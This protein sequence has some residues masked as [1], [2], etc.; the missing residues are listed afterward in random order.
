MSH[1][2]KCIMQNY[3]TPGAKHRGKSRWQWLFR[4]STKC[5]IHER[6]NY[7]LGFIKFKTSAC[8]RR[9]QG[10]KTSHRLGENTVVPP[11]P[12]GIWMSEIVDSSQP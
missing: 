12:W 8:E 5:T 6:N 9:C 2:P 1:R 10:N 7:K 3:K 4:Y 11:Y